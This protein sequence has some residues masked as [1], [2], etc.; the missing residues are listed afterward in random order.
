M[1]LVAEGNVQNALLTRNPRL[2]SRLSKQV[3]SGTRRSASL[4]KVVV[5]VEATENNSFLTSKDYAIAGAL[6]GTLVTLVLHPVDTIKTLIQARLTRRTHTVQQSVLRALGPN[7][8]NALYR[9]VG[10]SLCSSAPISALYTTT[11]EAVR[12]WCINLLTP[13]QSWVADCIAGGCAS[14]VTSFVY[15]PSECLKQRTQLGLEQNVFLAARRI[16]AQQGLLG[17]YQ[18]WRAVLIRNIPHN[19]F[20][21]YTFESLRRCYRETFGDPSGLTSLICGGIAGSLA[22]LLTNPCD[23]IKTK[24]MV[25]RHPSPSV[26]QVIRRILCQEGILGFYH[27]LYPRLF[28]Y[29]SQGALFFGGYEAAKFFLSRMHAHHHS[30]SA[31][32]HSFSCYKATRMKAE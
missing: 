20:K 4:G 8:V 11:L 13:N 5:R 26:V 30:F 32:H 6:A 22:A 1:E 28:I 10:A 3:C 12:W 24:I 2:Y 7:H 25:D 31:H 21:W 23:V 19:I 16:I 9:G 15:T 17:L 29:L 27:G 14:I 18:G